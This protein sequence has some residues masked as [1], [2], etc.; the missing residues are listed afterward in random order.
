MTTGK[1]FATAWDFDPS[2][3]VGCV[4]LLGLYFLAVRFRFDRFGATFAGGVAIM[5]LSLVSPIDALGDDYLFSAHMLQHIVLDLVAPALFVMGLPETMVRGWL[6]L[7]SIDRTERV[8]GAPVVAWFLG[9]GTLAIWHLPYLYNAT[10]ANEYIHIFE[11]ITFLITGTIL[12]W[13]VLS[14]IRER[15]LPA[16][17]AV[18]YL[19]L[20]GLANSL[21]GIFFTLANTA[22]YSGYLHPDDE[23]GALS[24]IRNTWGL[25]PVA[26]QKLGGAFMWVIGSVIFLAAIL[27]MVARWFREEAEG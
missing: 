3:V 8:L 18:I 9:T 24:L 19:I 4:L 22:F 7:R 27:V 5:F 14:P 17:T 6:R 20:A 15:R 21:V 2:I 1:L 16:M 11:H 10:L 23:L 13:P 26:D 12:W 25:D